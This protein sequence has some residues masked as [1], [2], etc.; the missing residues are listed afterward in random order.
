MPDLEK[1]LARIH[2]TRCNP[3]E[4]YAT[5]TAFEKVATAFPPNSFQSTFKSPLLRS[6]FEST[7]VIKQDVQYFLQLMDEDAAKMGVKKNLFH[8]REK[9]PRVVELREVCC[10]E[11]ILC[12]CDANKNLRS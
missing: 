5:L 11:S 10:V 2:Y 1:N 3:S 7:H 4:L 9:F 12:H 6:L 8:D